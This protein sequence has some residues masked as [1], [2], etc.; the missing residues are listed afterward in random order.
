MP[1][2]WD[3]K[4]YDRNHSFVSELA[5]NLIDLLAP[6][7]GERILDLG[8]GTGFLTDKIASQGVE[9]IGIDYATTMI[10]QAR[11][12][13]PQLH[14]EVLDARNL[15]YQEEFDAVFSNAALH[16]ITE[17]EKVIFG[18]HQALKPGG[19]FV[20][21]FGGQGNIKGITTA[22]Y[23]A[24]EKASYPVNKIPRIWYFPSI[25]EYGSLLE[26]HDL[27]LIFAT[28]FN[29]PTRLEEGEKGMQNWLK[30]FANSFL[31][32]FSAEQQANIISDIE[33]QLRPVLYQNGTWF[34]DYCRIRIVAVKE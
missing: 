5:T 10:E 19:R 27:Q 32:T 11:D 34:A 29:R 31:N 13:Y 14:F 23:Q 30:M 26:K 18:I 7:A 24:L 33:N 8:C 3:A 20:A 6:Q 1:N 21:E 9:V 4:L 25:A 15:H 12:K 2:Q 28:L 17:P 16:W 22:L